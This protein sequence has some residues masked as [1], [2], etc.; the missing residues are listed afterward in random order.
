M[1]TVGTTTAVGK[2]SPPTLV[3]ATAIGTATVTVTVA[4]VIGTEAAT[5]ATVIATVIATASVSATGLAKTGVSDPQGVNPPL[6]RNLHQLPQHNRC[7]HG[8]RKRR[9]HSRTSSP[10]S[11]QQSATVAAHS[12]PKDLAVSEGSPGLPKS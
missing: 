8:R 6:H 3:T 11:A 4:A 10:E 1:I 2:A 12:A 9:R 7:Q 5:V